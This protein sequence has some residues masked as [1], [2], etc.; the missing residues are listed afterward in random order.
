MQSSTVRR[1]DFLRVVAI[2]AVLAGASGGCTA[3]LLGNPSGGTATGSTTDQSLAS[4]VRAAFA[5]ARLPERAAIA[6]SANGSSVTLTGTVR[7]AAVRAEAERIA[8]GVSGVARVI[9]QL[10]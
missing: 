3:L 5:A 6:V 9:N 2:A 1:L 4:D 8:A 10:N 7:S